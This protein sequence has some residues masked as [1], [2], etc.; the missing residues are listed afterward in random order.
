MQFFSPV[1]FSCTTLWPAQGH[2]SCAPLPTS[3][4]ST[5]AKEYIV[6]LNY[7][8]G[9]IGA[10][11]GKISFLLNQ[12]AQTAHSVARGCWS[13]CMTLLIV[14]IQFL[15]WAGSWAAWKSAV[16]QKQ[17]WDL[18]GKSVTE[19]MHMLSILKQYTVLFNCGTENLKKHCYD[20]LGLSVFNS[21]YQFILQD[22]SY[23]Q[24][25]NNMNHTVFI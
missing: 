7:S 4:H 14:P 8:D 5:E 9:I 3:L 16:A 24:R 17:R 13:W 22:Y 6:S 19:G 23:N 25:R 15:A 12:Q 21:S 11:G 18:V 2:H 10:W 20:I 1:F